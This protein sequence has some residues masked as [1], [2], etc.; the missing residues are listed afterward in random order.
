MADKKPRHESTRKIGDWGEAQARAY[1]VSKG[2]KILAQ[3]I[4]T[5]YGEID[6]VAQKAGR[7]HFVE[8]KTKR[9]KSFGYPEEA[10]TERKLR[11]MTESAQSYIQSH[12]ELDTDYQLDVPAIQ[13]DAQGNQEIMCFENVN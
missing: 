10:V 7:L 8:V 11:H 2:F 1:L 6:L 12:P 4:Y 13:V 9:T 3:N 5:E